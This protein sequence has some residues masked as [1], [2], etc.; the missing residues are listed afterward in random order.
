VE[1]G[2]TPELL[3][4]RVFREECRAYPDAIRAVLESVRKS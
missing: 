1:P 4:A 3:A 2:D